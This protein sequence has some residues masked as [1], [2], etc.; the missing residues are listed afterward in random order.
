MFG[1]ADRCLVCSNR[2]Y[3]NEK[4]SADGKV[5]HKSCFR[6]SHCSK[7]LSLGTYAS[8]NGVYYCKPHFKSL[9]KRNG[10][11]SEGF[12]LEKPTAKWTPTSETDR[13]KEI[14]EQERKRDEQRQSI[15]HREVEVDV[16]SSSTPSSMY[17]YEIGLLFFLF[18]FIILIVDVY[19]S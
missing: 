10:N 8:L 17:S 15:P 4:L 6:C 14:E 12:G 5:F 1:G 18:Y 13:T 7:V 19:M 2:V 11:Y 9:F 16:S 3:F